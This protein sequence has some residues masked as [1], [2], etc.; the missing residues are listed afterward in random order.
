MNSAPGSVTAITAGDW[1][2]AVVS[3]EEAQTVCLACHVCP[4]GDALGSMLA[5]EV[6]GDAAGAERV[7]ESVHIITHATSL[8][9]VESLMERRHRWAGEE[10]TPPTLLRLSVGCE[11]VDDLIADLE[12]AL[13]A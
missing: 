9:G 11:H 1:H 10:A 12:Q 6:V 3:V 7:A 2:R 13:A 8:G 5:F 4:D